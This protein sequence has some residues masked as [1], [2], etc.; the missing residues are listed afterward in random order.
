MTHPV[1]T[2]E[3]AALRTFEGALAFRYR[4]LLHRALDELQERRM[5]D[6]EDVQK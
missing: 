2:E 5:K 3:I 4:A 6:E 1:T